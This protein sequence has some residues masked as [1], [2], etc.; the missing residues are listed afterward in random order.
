VAEQRFLIQKN[1]AILDKRLGEINKDGKMLVVLDTEDYL[2][3]KETIQRYELGIDTAYLVKY[4]GQGDMDFNTLETEEHYPKTSEYISFEEL[5]KST[6]G[7]R[8]MAGSERGS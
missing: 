1:A 6:K 2:N 4:L 8:V 5:M 7:A 3:A